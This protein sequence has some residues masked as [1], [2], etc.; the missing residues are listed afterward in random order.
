MPKAAQKKPTTMTVPSSASSIG[1]L[2]SN[3]AD[4]SQ[5][6]SNRNECRPGA[7]KPQPVEDVAIGLEGELRL[8]STHRG[9]LQ[10]GA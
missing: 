10:R 5:I 6:G 2:N 7:G 3:A 1:L 8:V 4:A 9:L